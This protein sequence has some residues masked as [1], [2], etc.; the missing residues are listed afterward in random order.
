[1][2]SSVDVCFYLN[3]KYFGRVL[4]NDLLK[5]VHKLYILSF[6]LHRQ[7]IILCC[8][9]SP[10]VV[11]FTH[12][13]SHP[14]VHLKFN[15]HGIYPLVYFICICDHIVCGRT[16]CGVYTSPFMFSSFFFHQV[17]LVINYDLPNNRELYIHRIGRS[18]RFGRKVFILLCIVDGF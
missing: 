18:G 8:H 14:L 4:E 7:V 3:V 9:F 15:N 16:T 2:L 5:K 6:V 1:M 17:S 10:Y 13:Q 11:C 12:E